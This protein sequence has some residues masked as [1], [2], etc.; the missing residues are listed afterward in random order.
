MT[1]A[2]T[3]RRWGK[4]F[5]AAVLIASTSTAGPGTALAVQRPIV[6]DVRT[7]QAFDFS[8]GQSPENI[9]VDPDGS[10]T[11]SMLGSPAGQRPQ[12]LRIGPG[13]RRTVLVTGQQG[14]TITGNTRGD[15]GT[16]YYNVW[17]PDP[18][19]TGIWR[20]TGDHPP[21]RIVA[22]PADGLPNGL[23]I[24]PAGRTLYVSDST[25]AIV[26]TAPAS[27]GPASS[28]L[29]DRALAP[30][31]STSFGANGLRF[32]AGAVWVANLSQGTLLRIPVTTAGT[33][34]PIHVVSDDVEGIDDFNFLNSRSDVVFA[35]LNGPNQ[36]VVVHPDGTRST[37]LTASDGLASPTA[38]A[39]RGRSL[40][41]TNGGLA[42]PHDAKLLRGTIDIAALLTP[43]N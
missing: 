34:G 23:A 42:E 24:D 11:V 29:A 16:V 37:V 40:Y 36:I 26:W 20:I 39:V 33:A 1:G 5:A 38:T 13:A 43:P 14:D 25:K 7:V 32:H 12:L 31:P 9:T 6:T 3:R 35:A 27:G 17:S 21:R 28:W 30:T 19:R 8:A 15:D 18:S 2:T 4:V 10:L 22:L 41:I